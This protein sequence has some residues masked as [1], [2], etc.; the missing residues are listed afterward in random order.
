MRL[1]LRPSACS[2]IEPELHDYAA[3]LT[4][5]DCYLVERLVVWIRC[6]V[7]CHVL[8]QVA[9]VHLEAVPGVKGSGSVRSNDLRP[10]LGCRGFGKLGIDR[11]VMFAENRCLVSSASLD[12]VDAMFECR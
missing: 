6:D 5:D 3:C 1:D 9:L 4:V 11:E 7:G 12:L 10:L 8:E 2:R